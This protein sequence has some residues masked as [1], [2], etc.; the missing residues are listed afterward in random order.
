MS[1]AFLEVRGLVKH[2]DSRR[3]WWGEVTGN[4][5]HVVRAVDG[6][7]LDIARGETLGLIGESGCGKSTLGRAVL[8]LYEPTSGTVKLD[9]EDVTAADPTRLKALR[10]RMQIIFQDPYASLNPRR[11]V[12]SIISRPMVLH[13]TRDRREIETRMRDVADRVGLAPSMLRRYPHQFSGGQR[14]RIGIARALVLHPDLVVCDEP[15]SALDVSI[16]AQVIELLQELKRELSLTYLFVSHDI[17]VIG[18]VSDRVAV[19]YLGEIV[20]TGP[21]RTV[22]KSPS[23]PYTQALISAAPKVTAGSRERTRLE[24]DP[25]SPMNPPQGCRFH[26]RCPHVMPICR[27]QAPGPVELSRDVTVRC[28]LHGEGADEPQ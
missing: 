2:Y 23:H 26:T 14:Q 19:M 27:E 24:G 3:G 12:A 8:R 6:V 21:A 15:V 7:D 11:D 5:G 20:E 10:R 25:P 16:Q 22:L 13:G 17:A 1:T 4:P 28:H 9:G 18:Y